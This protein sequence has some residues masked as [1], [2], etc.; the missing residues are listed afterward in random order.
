M[1][2]F[3]QTKVDRDFAGGIYLPPLGPSPSLEQI[4]AVDYSGELLLPLRWG[5]SC[6]LNVIPESGRRVSRDTIIAK[7]DEGHFLFAPRAGTIGPQA[8]AWIDNQPNQPVLTLLPLSESDD[9]NEQMETEP[10]AASVFDSLSAAQSELQRKQKVLDAIRQAGIVDPQQGRP[11]S[12]TLEELETTNIKTVIANATPLEFQINTPLAVLHQFSEQVF[13][14]LAILKT[15]L[16]ADR[17]LM[18]YPHHFHIDKNT[19]RQWQVRCVP[20][21][22][23]Y[24]QGTRHSIL[25]TLI[26]QRV[27]RR[28]RTAA[29]AAVFSIQLLR[30][31]ER[32]VLAGQKPTERIVTICGDGVSRPGHFLAPLGMPLMEL[33]HRAGMYEDAQCVALKSSLVGD[34]INPENAVITPLSEGFV[35]LQRVVHPQPLRC[36]RCGRCIEHCPAQI[37]PA[38]LLQLAESRQFARAVHIGAKACI[39][40][41][42]CS[43]I[44]PS[45]LR[46]MEHIRMIK[47][48]THLAPDEMQEPEP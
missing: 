39:D 9:S 29:T 19:A 31:I 14:G 34:P 26:K 23:K 42:I 15:F 47:S 11:F 37:D 44:C 3:T 21:S 17:A 27:L 20:V 25:G 28:K 40:C 32:A 45:H 6:L 7:N 38:R 35:V 24:P 36:I 41:G 1:E 18:T 13:A 10:H 8:A 46:I 5:T 4:Q 2:L 33:L 22:E 16:G 48:N 30:Q 43:Y 12:D